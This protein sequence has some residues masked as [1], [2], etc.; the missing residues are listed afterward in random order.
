V[1]AILSLDVL[2]QAIGPDQNVKIALPKSMDINAVFDH[3]ASLPTVGLDR[4]RKIEVAADLIRV[5][6][7]IWLESDLVQS[8]PAPF[9][10]DFQRR[11]AAMYA[12]SAGPL[13]RRLFVARRGP[14]RMIHNLA[15]VQARLSTFGFETVYLEGMSVRDQILLFQSADFVIGPHGAG[16]ANLL[17]CQPETKV[18]EL[19][20]TVEMRP[21]FWLTSQKLG[22]VYGVQFCDPA[23]DQGFQASISVDVDKLDALY[24][25]VDAH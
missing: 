22:L 19:T 25:I 7:A 12:T 9:L 5:E 17:F 16:L 14:T 13:R 15:Q 8:M 21:F 23:E 2:V 4:Y 20:P 18:I 6:E 24:R 1:E 10:Q 11:V 3:R